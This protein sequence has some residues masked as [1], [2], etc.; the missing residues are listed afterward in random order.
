MRVMKSNEQWLQEAIKVHG[1]KY[2]YDKVKYINNRTKVCI[3]CSIHGEFFQTPDMHIRLKYGCK[4][5]ST[6]LLK[7]KNKK[8]YAQMFMQKAKNVHNNKYK[9]SVP[10]YFSAID[11]IE[12][13]C[14]IHGN[15]KQIANQH[16]QGSGCP[17]CADKLRKISK[18]KPLNSFINDSKIIHGDKYDYSRV[19][20]VNSRTNV[21]IICPEHG[22]FFQTPNNHLRGAGCIKCTHI[23][24]PTT[25]E[26]IIKAKSVHGDKYDYSKIEYINQYTKVC[27]ICKQIE[28][29]TGKEHGEFYTLPNNHLRVESCPKCVG[30]NKT[31]EEWIYAAKEVN[32]DKY[33][34]SKVQYVNSQTN[35]C[36]ICQKHG[37]F[38]QR[39]S[40]HLQGVGCPICNESKSCIN[41]G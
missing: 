27:V 26:W 15:F 10:L 4:K 7:E 19:E 25:K 34:Y 2:N 6:Q 41:F 1:D 8:A 39:A 38:Y 30:R 12:I 40:Y 11:K 32:G 33:D 20:Y 31:T 14:S 35:V 18:T 17:K 9:Y 29:L 13:I 24:Q 23:Y 21:C 5:C 22:K 16:L 28:R 3:I 37:E 36:I